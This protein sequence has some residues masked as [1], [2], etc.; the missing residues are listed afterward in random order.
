MRLHRTSPSRRSIGGRATTTDIARLRTVE[1][2]AQ[3]KA[4]ARRARTVIHD[5]EAAEAA[6]LAALEER[7]RRESGMCDAVE[8]VASIADLS[9]AAAELARVTEAWSALAVT[10]AALLE[11]FE[12]GP[13]GCRAVHHPPR[14]RSGRSR[15]PSSAPRRSHRNPRRPLRPRRDPRRQRCARSTRSYRRRV[16]IAPAARRQR[17]GG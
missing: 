2:R 16:A 12:R 11:R 1:T 5:T 10:D 13:H 15:R 4:V 17:P 3:Q 8:Q 9:A 7:R 14:T 6:R